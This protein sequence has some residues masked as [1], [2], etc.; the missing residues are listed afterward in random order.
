MHG[1]LNNGYWSVLIKPATG[2]SF[3]DGVRKLQTASSLDDKFDVRVITKIRI[4]LVKTKSNC[5]VTGLSKRLQDILR[6]NLITHEVLDLNCVLKK[7]E[8]Q[9]YLT[10]NWKR[11]K[12]ESFSLNSIVDVYERKR[13]KSYDV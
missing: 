9:W 2:Q 10:T 5:D 13:E 11:K 7:H 12:T 4:V 8:V 6:P 1:L 3:A